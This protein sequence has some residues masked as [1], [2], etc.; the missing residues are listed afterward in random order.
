M[1]R[2]GLPDLD[3][4]DLV[5]DLCNRRVGERDVVA[6]L[7]NLFEG[8]LQVENRR[9]SERPARHDIGGTIHTLGAKVP[10]GR[11]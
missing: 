8:P 7:V 2:L 5:V 4:P 10:P 3:S 1:F 6:A 9:C 11:V